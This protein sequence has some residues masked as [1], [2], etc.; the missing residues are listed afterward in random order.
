MSLSMSPKRRA[1]PVPF[2]GGSTSNEK[3]VFSLEFI[4]SI[5][6]ILS[7]KIGRQPF[8]GATPLN[9]KVKVKCVQIQNKSDFFK[10]PN[11]KLRYY[12]RA[13]AIK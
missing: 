6:L 9:H 1:V 2:I 3:A 10:N 13:K 12:K 5:T 4:M 7:E 11:H 8:Y